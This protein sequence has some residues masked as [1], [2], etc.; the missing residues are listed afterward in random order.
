M[1]FI[2][3]FFKVLS[4]CM[5]A[6]C[7]ATFS[8]II[9]CN[10]AYPSKLTAGNAADV[11]LSPFCEADVL[12]KSV[13]ASISNGEVYESVMKI[14]GI[15]P[16]KNVSV[17][18][19][20]KQDVT[21][22]G[23]PFGVML[24]S[25]GVMVVGNSDFATETGNANPAADAG[26]LSGDTIISIDG[27]KMNS[28]DDVTKAIEKSNGH[29][30]KLEVLRNGK[31]NIIKA[32]AVKCKETGKYCLGIWIRDSSAGIGTMTF[33]NPHT[34][35][36]VGLGHAIC[37]VD[38]GEMVDIAS[39]VAVK[40]NIFGIKKGSAGNP[41]ELYGSLNLYSVIGNVVDN[42]QTGI[43]CKS[44]PVEG[45]NATVAYWQDIKPG[46]AK[47]LVSVDG[48]EPQY[49]DAKIDTIYPND[50]TKNMTVTITDKR[51]LSQTGGI[52]QGM[53]GSPIIQDGKLVGALTHVFVNNPTRGYG[54][55]AETMLNNT[56]K[57]DK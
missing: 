38:T 22:C 23:T 50:A 44:T 9:Y 28:V 13:T 39:G 19:I 40:A 42:N 1:K 21:L 15:V 49:Y 55:F 18:V 45:H 56:K 43:Y 26:I 37:D 31:K 25:N 41:G 57:L 36:S 53:S 5:A 12:N 24:Y 8:L 11:R 47:I 17:S 2:N 52:V 48:E 20:D 30:M 29:Q 33:Y 46:A 27:I 34:G 4:A 51:L 54:I 14:F 7:A 32:T 3:K 6:A 10:N 16:V 35:I